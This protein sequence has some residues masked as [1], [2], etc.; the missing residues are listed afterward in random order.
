MNIKEVFKKCNNSDYVIDKYKRRWKV[1]NG[2]LIS[3]SEGAILKVRPVNSWNNYRK[4]MFAYCYL[5][6]QD[7]ENKI[8]K[9][10]E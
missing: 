3:E 10:V 7:V 2:E 8:T 6:E 1:D 5:T 9:V 4:E